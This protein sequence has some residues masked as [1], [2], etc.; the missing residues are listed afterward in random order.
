MGKRR[1]NN[2]NRHEKGSDNHGRVENS[3]PEPKINPSVVPPKPR[4]PTFKSIFG[5]NNTGDKPDGS[6]SA[7]SN[8][9]SGARSSN[10]CPQQKQLEIRNNPP[11]YIPAI[12]SNREY[13]LS[14]RRNDPYHYSLWRDAY[15]SYLWILFDGFQNILNKFKVFLEEEIS[16][17]TFS[18]FI[19]EFSSGYISPYA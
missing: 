13:R 14:N 15:D 2:R 4:P 10:V 12:Q 3:S 18:F 17:N 7:S 16:F 11:I 9:E 19:Y 1:R 5:R 8:I 6:L